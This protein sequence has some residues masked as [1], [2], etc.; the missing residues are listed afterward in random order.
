MNSEMPPDDCALMTIKKQLRQGLRKRV[1]D[2]LNYPTAGGIN[3][4][5]AAMGAEY[6]CFRNLMLGTRF[7][8]PSCEGC[9]LNPRGE[10]LCGIIHG[11][12]RFRTSDL[13]GLII[14][15]TQIEALAEALDDKA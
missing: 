14:A 13:A 8:P 12:R 6:L 1:R 10:K 9:Q 5:I 11:G 2:F 3:E 7:D 4:I 15:L